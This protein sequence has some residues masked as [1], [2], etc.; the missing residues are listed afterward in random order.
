MPAGTKLLGLRPLSSTSVA[1]CPGVNGL[2]PLL[3]CKMG[4]VLESKVIV[5]IK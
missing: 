2:S 3:I 4:M 1:V 5:K